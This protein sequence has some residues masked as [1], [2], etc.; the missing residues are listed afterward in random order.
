MAKQ[1]LPSKI[2]KAINDI[3]RYSWSDELDDYA[4]NPYEAH[5]FVS[6]VALDNWANGTKKKAEDYVGEHE[7]DQGDKG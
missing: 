6:L 3:V 7:K 2:K 5:V 4:R 1:Q